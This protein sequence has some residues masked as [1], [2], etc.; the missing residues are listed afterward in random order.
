MQ[1]NK[2]LR[3]HDFDGMLKRHRGEWGI[4]IDHFAALVID[5]TSYR[6]VQYGDEGTVGPDGNFVEDAKSGRP[7]VW[8]ARYDEETDTTQRQLCEGDAL[9][10]VSKVPEVRGETVPIVEDANLAA[11]RAENPDD[12]NAQTFEECYLAGLGE[13]P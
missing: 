6:V 7:G 13:N 8:L 2:V 5:G 4:C 1:S 11:A 12:G 3:H 9:D 10:E